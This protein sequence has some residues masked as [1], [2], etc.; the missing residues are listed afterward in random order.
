[1]LHDGSYDISDPIDINGIQTNEL[2]PLRYRYIA[3]NVLIASNRKSKQKHRCDRPWGVFDHFY[4]YVRWAHSI[5]DFFFCRSNSHV[6]NTHWWICWRSI[7]VWEAASQPISGPVLLEPYNCR[8]QCWKPFNICTF[9]CH[10]NG[11]I[12]SFLLR[13]AVPTPKNCEISRPQPAQLIWIRNK[14]IRTIAFMHQRC[15]CKSSPAVQHTQPVIHLTRSK[16]NRWQQMNAGRVSIRTYQMR[17]DICLS[18]VFFFV[19][20]SLHFSARVR[21]HQIHC[22]NRRALRHTA[23][24]S[25]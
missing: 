7:V 22:N 3:I 4:S 11:L 18:W 14:N 1:M 6:R 2:G 8:R 10:E 17:Y 12:K 23:H 19:R 15:R 25:M 9:F 20:L 21:Q 13:I 16:T 24:V 5:P